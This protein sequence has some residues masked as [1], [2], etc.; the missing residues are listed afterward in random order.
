MFQ[1]LNICSDE[2]CD[3]LDKKK[4]RGWNEHR[5]PDFFS[6]IE[7]SYYWKASAKEKC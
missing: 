5:Q 6:Q 7:K 1:L 4:I 2:N 3:N